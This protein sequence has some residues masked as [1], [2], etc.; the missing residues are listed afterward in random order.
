MPCYLLEHPHQV[1]HVVGLDDIGVQADQV[2]VARAGGGAKRGNQQLALV[3]QRHLVAVN[4]A[5][6]NGDASNGQL[7]RLRHGLG[8]AVGVVKQL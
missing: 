2:E 7:G 6:R 8:V 3:Q 5:G 4:V 1:A